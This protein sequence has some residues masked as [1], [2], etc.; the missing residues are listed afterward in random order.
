VY[1]E[2]RALI[3]LDDGTAANT[4]AERDLLLLLLLL[5]LCVV[6]I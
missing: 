1:V 5:L 6:V 2:M 4:F 3:V